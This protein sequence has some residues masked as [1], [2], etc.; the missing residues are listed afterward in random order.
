MVTED[1][2]MSSHHLRQ[3]TQEE[4]WVWWGKCQLMT[5][6][7]FVLNLGAYGIFNDC[8]QDLEKQLCCAFSL[9]H[10]FHLS[11]TL[12]NP[13]FQRAAI[14]EMLV[15][16]E[17]LLTTP[18]RFLGYNGPNIPPTHFSHLVFLWSLIIGIR[19]R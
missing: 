2:R 1:S 6:V 13:R 12:L 15:V 19:S 7:L 5:L 8:S 18:Y 4:E 16:T 10:D 14:Q 3:Q 9:C 17:S 11:L